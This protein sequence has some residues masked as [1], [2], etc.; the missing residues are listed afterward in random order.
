MVLLDVERSLKKVLDGRITFLQH[1]HGINYVTGYRP[2][3]VVDDTDVA[4]VSGL[5][6]C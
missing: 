5:I 2:E 4:F 3:V 6:D 1:K